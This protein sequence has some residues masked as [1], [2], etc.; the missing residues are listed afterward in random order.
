MRPDRAD[1]LDERWWVDLPVG[2][3]RLS[4][5]FGRALSDGFYLSAWPRLAAIAPPLALLLGLILGWSRIGY[6]STDGIDYLFSPLTVLLMVLV[7]QQ[8]AA[9]G[10]WMLL[11]FALGDLHWAFSGQD[12]VGISEIFLQ[13]LAPRALGDAIL[14]ILLV[15]CPLVSATV[16]RAGWA[17]LAS[18]FSGPAA[19]A[20]SVLLRAAVSAAMVYFWLGAAP[21]LTQAMF[22]WAGGSART[23][24]LV[25]TWATQGLGVAAVAGLAAG[26]RGFLVLLA[27]PRL[28]GRFTRL[29]AIAAQ[30]TT[31]SGPPTAVV[32]VALRA[33][34]VTLICGGLLA[35]WAAAGKLFVIGAAILAARDLAARWPPPWTPAL[36]RIPLAA[37][38]GGALAIV[39][40]LATQRA[41][42]PADGFQ[43]G[44]AMALA[45]LLVF[46]LLMP[47]ERPVVAGHGGPG[48]A[49]QAA[50]AVGM[51]LLAAMLWPD[52]AHAGYCTTFPDCVGG[53]KPLV[54]NCLTGIG[55]VAGAS[56]AK[57]YGGVWEDHSDDFG[58]GE[59]G[60]IVT[61]DDGGGDDV[62]GDGDDG[63]PDDDRI[64]DIAAPRPPRPPPMFDRPLGEDEPSG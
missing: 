62:G 10:L 9:L 14:A 38:A 30:S 41:A 7:S 23:H 24:G 34:F 4:P 15:A 63:G 17:R 55:V 64:D 48:R 18:R 44:V 35:S 12:G 61:I 31:A 32:G 11:G 57:A 25:Q 51:L 50:S 8:G 29:R 20:A 49:E 33:G 1:F 6:Y 27:Q 26:G 59:G 40:F 16:T 42:A 43:D 36:Q 2:A 47:P 53:S 3:A 21:V 60:Q 19:G 45:G 52:K 46:V 5:T 28:A 13:G 58:G 56:G 54:D 39:Y 22:T 37:R